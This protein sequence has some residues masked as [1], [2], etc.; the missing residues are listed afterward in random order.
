MTKG[1]PTFKNTPFELVIACR[2]QGGRR[3]GWKPDEQRQEK[4]VRLPE[5][6]GKLPCHSATSG[7]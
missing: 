1:K 5:K 4:D 2:S 7:T 3:Q 6:A